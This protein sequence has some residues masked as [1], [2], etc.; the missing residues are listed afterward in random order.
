M[1]TFKRKTAKDLINSSEKLKEYKRELRKSMTKLNKNFKTMNEVL[2]KNIGQTLNQRE[3]MEKVNKCHSEFKTYI[4]EFKFIE[5][6]DKLY[7]FISQIEEK[8]FDDLFRAKRYTP[9]Q[10]SS[11][12]NIVLYLIDLDKATEELKHKV[13]TDNNT[14]NTATYWLR[15]CLNGFSKC[16]DVW[17]YEL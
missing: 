9:E 2:E 3:N 12:K 5:D 17:E 14:F 4:A 6:S 8:C 13:W 16:E 11:I 1:A 7:K 15:D 10:A